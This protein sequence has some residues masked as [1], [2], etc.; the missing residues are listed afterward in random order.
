MHDARI[1][2][3][4][5]GSIIPT[6]PIQCLADSGY[7]G[8]GLY[9]HCVDCNICFIAQ[10]RK[11][12]NGKMTH[13]SEHNLIFEFFEFFEFLEFLEFLE[14]RFEAHCQEAHCWRLTASRLSAYQ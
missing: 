8:I 6:A 3:E 12:K 5:I 13:T 9:N 4:S 11:K 1:L 2:R 7:I 14:F 10:P